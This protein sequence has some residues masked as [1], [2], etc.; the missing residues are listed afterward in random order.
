MATFTLSSGANQGFVSAP[1]LSMSNTNT[2]F[3]SGSG[4]AGLA[5]GFIQ[6]PQQPTYGNPQPTY[7]QAQQ[8]YGAAVHPPV[9]PGQVQW[10][11]EPYYAANATES[12]SVVLR[13]NPPD[14]FKNYSAYLTQINGRF[15]PA[16]RHPND[17]N[18][19]LPGWIFST[20]QDPQV[21]ALV[22]QIVSGQIP[23]AASHNPLPQSSNL[24]GQPNQFNMMSMPGFQAPGQ[25][26][27]QTPGQPGLPIPGTPNF[28]IAAPG[29]PTLLPIN[30]IGGQVQPRMQTISI[31]KPAVG[32]TLYLVVDGTRYPLLVESVEKTGDYV[33]A[34]A[35]KLGDQTSRIELNKSFEWVVPSYSTP[36]KIEL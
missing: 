18:S 33:T 17:P 27:F 14:F 11:L 20:K 22:N 4:L 28:Q 32:E 9:A 29:Q 6:V 21:R 30:T 13:S 23:P 7:G 31:L 35:V 8:S 36:H 2:G 24:Q 26:G 34:A 5:S 1:G 10:S 25:S 16:L 19:R 15:N 3:A 12:K